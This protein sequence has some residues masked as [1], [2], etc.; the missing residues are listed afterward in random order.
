[1][2]A[3]IW[4]LNLLIAGLLAAPYG[5]AAQNHHPD[6]AGAKQEME[7]AA[8]MMPMCHQMMSSMAGR[9]MGMGEGMMGMMGSRAMGMMLSPRVI[10]M[11]KDALDLS[12][13]QI[14]RLESLQHRMD[15]GRE[16]GM[17]QG[18][19]MMQQLEKALDPENPDLETYESLLNQMADHHVQMQVQM[20]RLGIEALDVLTADQR[21]KVRYGMKLMHGMMGGMMMG[22]EHPPRQER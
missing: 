11:Q 17:S 3:T 5:A 19:S 2:K 1:M 18:H 12:D 15:H 14:E 21:E 8:G 7:S 9:G 16:P 13:E 22:G 10:L 4:T 6:E 20:A